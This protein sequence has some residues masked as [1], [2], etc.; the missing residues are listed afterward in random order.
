MRKIV[1]NIIS[2]LISFSPKMQLFI[3][4]KGNSSR[5]IQNNDLKKL[6]KALITVENLKTHK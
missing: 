3:K 4:F 5:G 6:I 2:N 1:T